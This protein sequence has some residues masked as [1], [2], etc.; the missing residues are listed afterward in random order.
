MIQS[1]LS[2]ICLFGGL[3]NMYT[4]TAMNRDTNFQDGSAVL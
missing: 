4:S 3:T 1:N 2:L